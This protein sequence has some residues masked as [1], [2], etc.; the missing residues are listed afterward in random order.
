MLRRVDHVQSAA[1]HADGHASAPQGAPSGGGIHAPG[2]AADHNGP[3][4][5]QTVAQLLAAGLT[6][7]R[8]FPGTHHRDDGLLVDGWQTAPHIQQKGR[9]VD[10]SQ[11]VGILRVL[12]CQDP[13]P[14]PAAVLKDFPGGGKALAV[15]R[16]RLLS[17]NALCQ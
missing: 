8:A 17:G 1:Q 6:V 12:K 10:I 16:L 7:G 15:Q 11:P 14:Q 3:A 4:S 13:Q 9:V 2:K 5:G